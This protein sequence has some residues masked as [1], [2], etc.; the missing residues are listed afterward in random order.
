MNHKTGLPSNTLLNNNTRI[1]Y[2]DKD[3]PE[4]KVCENVMVGKDAF[5]LQKTLEREEEEY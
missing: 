4:Q 1:I 5:S 3:Q 2:Q